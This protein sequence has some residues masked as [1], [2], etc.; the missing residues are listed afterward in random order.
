VIL[1]RNAKLIWIAVPCA[2]LGYL[3][4]QVMGAVGVVANLLVMGVPIVIGLAIGLVALEPSGQLRN[5]SVVTALLIAIVLAA[6]VFVA[7]FAHAIYSST[8]L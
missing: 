7:E 4:A 6:S 3:I 1:A 8:D 5:R 2:I